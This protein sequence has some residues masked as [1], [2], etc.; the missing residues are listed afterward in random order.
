MSNRPP[1]RKRPPDERQREYEQIDA[2]APLADEAPPDRVD[3]T[4]AKRRQIALTKE[5]GE[6]MGLGGRQ[7]SSWLWAKFPNN[8]IE[9]QMDLPPKNEIERANWKPLPGHAQDRVLAAYIWQ[10]W[11]WPACMPY[12]VVLDAGRHEILREDSNRHYLLF[13]MQAVAD[14]LAMSKQRVSAITASLLAEK[15]IRVE[16]P[17][18]RRNGYAVYPEPRPFL[19]AEERASVNSTVVRT[20]LEGPRLEPA[21]LR[22]FS[23]LLNKLG[24]DTDT[25]LVPPEARQ[26]GEEAEAPQEMLVKDYRTLV[27]E[28]LFDART[29]FLSSL[30]NLRYSERKTYGNIGTRARHLI[31][32]LQRPETPSSYSVRPANPAVLPPSG[33]KDGRT[34]AGTSTY[35]APDKTLVADGEF[36]KHVTELYRTHKKGVASVTLLAAAWK[37]WPADAGLEDFE[38]FLLRPKGQARMDRTKGVGALVDQVA[39]FAIEWKRGAKARAEFKADEERQ[40]KADEAYN[41]QQLLL[42]EYTAENNAAIDMC[43]QALSI[44]ELKRL[45]AEKRHVLKAEKITTMHGSSVIWWDCATAENRAGRIEQMIRADLAKQLPTFDEWRQKKAEKGA[46]A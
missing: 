42:H 46:G 27:W 24:D 7:A 36:Y 15:R 9:A 32:H 40:R 3:D 38:N 11:C 25:I 39:E 18:G 6:Q 22:T 41:A 8:L 4:A 17:R 19:T 45:Q 21:V 5:L 33:S 30:K 35:T 28:N 37:L 1:D 20:G 31:D 10:S 12:A 34:G 16:I 13:S 23:N 26:D 44:D 14:L 43:Y 2:D 29:A